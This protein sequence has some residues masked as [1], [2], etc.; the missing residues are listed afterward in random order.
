[1]CEDGAEL[2][3]CEEGGMAEGGRE[4]GGEGRQVEPQEK[5]GAFCFSSSVDI[6]KGCDFHG[7]V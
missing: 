5:F 1:M 7:N 6:C 2:P 4:G 3:R